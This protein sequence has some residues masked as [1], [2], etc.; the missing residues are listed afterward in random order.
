MTVHPY[1]GNTVHK[2]DETELKGNFLKWS[3]VKHIGI[4]S[5][6][7]EDS[8]LLDRLKNCYSLRLQQTSQ[9]S[10]T[11]EALGGK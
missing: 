5:P 11:D 6:S 8:V 10:E 7:T 3:H 4:S 1:Q 9:L 2:Q